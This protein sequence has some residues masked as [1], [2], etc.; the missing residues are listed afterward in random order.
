MK[1][2]QTTQFVLRCSVFSCRYADAALD[3]AMAVHTRTKYVC[4]ASGLTNYKYNAR[5]GITRT[6][7]SKPWNQRS[8]FKTEGTEQY[9][10][11]AWPVHTEFFALQLSVISGLNIA[12]QS[13]NKI[14]LDL[15]K[16]G[17]KAHKNANIPS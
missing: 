11:P 2:V 12:F 5:F 7:H 16:Q 8:L 9:L 1:Q 13:H 3:G 15:Q 14:I 17:K 6:C 4:E 10:T